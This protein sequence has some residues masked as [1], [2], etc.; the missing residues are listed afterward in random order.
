MEL[1]FIQVFKALIFF[2]NYK[3][4][5]ILNVFDYLSSGFMKSRNVRF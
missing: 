5:T 1:H 2:S 4:L 3:S